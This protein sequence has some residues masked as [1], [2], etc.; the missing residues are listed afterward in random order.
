MNPPAPSGYA[1]PP[2]RSTGAAPATSTLR[3]HLAGQLRRLLDAADVTCSPARDAVRLL[4]GLLGPAAGRPLSAGPLSPSFVSDDHSPAELSVSFAADGAPT[5]RVLVEPGCGAGTAADSGRA[6][7][8]ALDRMASCWD[9]DAEPVARVTDLFL[10]AAARGP[11]SLW[12][13][14]DLRRTG[15]PGVKVYLNPEAH[16]ADRA[17]EVVEEALTR[18]GFR[19]AWPALTAR[20]ESWCPDRGRLLFL[21]LD[22]G[23]WQEPRVKLYIAHQGFSVE[24]AEAVAGLLPGRNP[25]RAGDFCRTVGGGARRFDGLPLVSCLSFTRRD[26]ERPSGHT[27]HVPV[28]DYAS[29]DR[30]ARDRAAAVLGA[31]GADVTLLDKALAAMTPRRLSDGVGLISYVS[32]ARS[33]GGPPRLTVYL[34]PEAY[35]VHPPHDPSRDTAPGE[36][37]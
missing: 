22:L 21:A 32:L 9:V 6:G 36:R 18:F 27:L 2:Q 15:P 8:R 30:V 10:P 1:L 34:S 24:E 33:T 26:R 20:A 17:A 7:L 19:A 5:V 29:D 12:C 31:H 13:A 14:V 3:E 23:H 28:R 11:F 4:P 16:G 35:A 37:G 25:R